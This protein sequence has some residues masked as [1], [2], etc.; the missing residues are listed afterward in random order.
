MSR[1]LILAAAVLTG[2]ML[3][4]GCGP[5][6]TS[7]G[8]TPPSGGRAGSIADEAKRKTEEVGK[9]IED[10]GKKMADAAG[11]KVKELQDDITKQLEPVNKKIAELK[12]KVEDEKDAGAKAEASKMLAAG[13]TKLKEVMDMV[14]S[15]FAPEKLKG[16]MEGD[17]FDKLKETIMAKIADLKKAVGL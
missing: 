5:T 7:G 2:S 13:E 1:K 12:K 15:S 8:A 11:G 17:T 9:K 4:V 16:L 10:G 3:V 14:K 6:P